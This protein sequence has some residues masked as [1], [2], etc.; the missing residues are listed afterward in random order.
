ML[1]LTKMMHVIVS[2]VSDSDLSYLHL[3]NVV[4]GC[5]TRD[6][7]DDDG[8]EDEEEEDSDRAHVTLVRTL[9]WQVSS[10]RMVMAMIMMMTTTI[11]F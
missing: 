5:C 1:L 6:H 7:D 3:E 10:R 8:E 11:I 4:A 9:T 2:G